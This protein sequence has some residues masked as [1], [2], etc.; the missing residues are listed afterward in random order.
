MISI[1][2]ELP[3]ASNQGILKIDLMIEETK[4]PWKTLSSNKIY[5]NPW[6][7]LRE[8]KVITPTG[9][10]GIYGVVEPKG[11]AI[12]IAALTPDNHI[13]LVG[14]YRYPMN[15]YSWEIPEGGSEPPESPLDTAKRELREEAG[16]L[17]SNW[18]QLGGEIHLSNCYT[19]ERGFLFLA[20]D[21]EETE[22][23]PDETEVLQV[24]KLPFA[25]VLEMVERGEIN[26]S[27]TMLAVLQLVRK[28]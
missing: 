10:S 14:Q 19:T 11:F 26:D 23:A 24:K 15:T 7:S 12:G 1:I 9:E 21:L 16:I 18:E 27:L 22:K 28:L 3:L 5:Q 17:A 6:I 4:N 2:N 13:Y 20:R 25:V 8:D